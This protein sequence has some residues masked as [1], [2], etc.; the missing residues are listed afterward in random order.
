MPPNSENLFS[1]SYKYTVN[2]TS[3]CMLSKYASSSYETQVLT[4]YHIDLIM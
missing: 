4:N 1:F 3:P 2:C